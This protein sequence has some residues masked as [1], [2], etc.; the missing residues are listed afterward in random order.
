MFKHTVKIPV[1]MPK[2][3]R[4]LFDEA[5]RKVRGAVIQLYTGSGGRPDLVGSAVSIRFRKVRYLA[6]AHHVLVQHAQSGLF[7]GQSDGLIVPISA[8]WN[9]TEKHDVACCKLPED[10]DLSHIPSIDITPAS[11]FSST[12]KLYGTAVGYPASKFK[13]KATV[14]RDE[15]FSLCDFITLN[16]GEKVHLTFAKG[17]VNLSGTSGRRSAPDPYG[18]SGGAI[19]AAPC[20]LL[21]P[22]EPLRLI[23]IATRWIYT[24]RR[25]EGAGIGVLAKLLAST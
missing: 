3:F 4:E 19:F 15:M 20:T 5:V 11:Q 16:D 1:L 21:A 17:R 12:P 18:I 24:K 10:L 6:T 23:G 13:L 25:I 14:V 9:Y 2:R 8:E 22:T 7:V